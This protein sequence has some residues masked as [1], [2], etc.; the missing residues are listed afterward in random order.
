MAADPSRL[1]LH[2]LADAGQGIDGRW[3]GA[4]MS[5]LAQDTTEPPG[6]V[7]WSAQAESRPVAGGDPQLWLHLRC[8]TSVRL[9]CQRCLQ[10]VGAHLQVDRWIRFVRDE[11]EAERLDEDSDDDV[12]ALG[13]PLDLRALVED[14]LILALPLVPKHEHCPEPLPTP[15]DDLPTDAP[16]DHPFQALAA[17]KRKP[18]GPV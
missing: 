5:R 4:S 1:D 17:L 11:A 13:G 18:S 12:L 3:P 2:R 10:A 7:T 14:E 16:A 15:A 8:A 9:T 6:E